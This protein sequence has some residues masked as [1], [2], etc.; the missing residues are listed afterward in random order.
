MCSSY[1]V[2][3]V[4]LRSTMEVFLLPKHNRAVSPDWSFLSPAPSHTP[5]FHVS[6]EAPDWSFSTPVFNHLPLVFPSADPTRIRSPALSLSSSVSIVLQQERPFLFDSAFVAPCRTYVS[7]RLTPFAWPFVPSERPFHRT[8]SLL[9]SSA[10]ECKMLKMHNNSTH[11]FLTYIG[12]PSISIER[13][14]FKL[15]C[16]LHPHT[17]FFYI[18]QSAAK[19][20]GIMSKFGQNY[21]NSYR[22]KC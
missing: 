7:Y 2:Y 21:I 5:A 19:R 14:W 13:G 4:I 15:T 10:S 20:I 16:V 17:F 18:D 3:V 1:F 22:L 8:L 12:L 6:W 9:S 11:K